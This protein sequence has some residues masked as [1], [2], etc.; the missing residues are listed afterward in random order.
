MKIR[1]C[2]PSHKY[3]PADFLEKSWPE[4]IGHSH[5]PIEQLHDRKLLRPFL[6]KRATL[7]LPLPVSESFDFLTYS[8]IYYKPDFEVEMP[9]AKFEY[10]DHEC[11]TLQEAEAIWFSRGCTFVDSFDPLDRS[12]W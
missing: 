3:G 5:L 6:S 7:A 11:Y 8:P 10:E 12:R 2:S 9:P 1:K 4:I